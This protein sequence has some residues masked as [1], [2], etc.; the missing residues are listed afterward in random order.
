MK[1]DNELKKKEKALNNFLIIIFAIVLLLIAGYNFIFDFDTIYYIFGKKRTAEM[2]ET[3]GITVTDDIK[4][5]KY[6]AF[7]F[8]A[9]MDYS[10]DISKIDDYNKFMQDNVNGK[11]IEKVEN[12]II[13]N[14]DKNTQE[15]SDYYEKD[16]IKYSY[17]WNGNIV[18]IWFNYTDNT[19]YYLASL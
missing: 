3:F 5:K 2:E 1:K 7:E 14:Y 13:Y 10:L 4:L 16:D 6:D 15:V 8:L 12:G 19:G 18:N 17:K 9:R 11:I